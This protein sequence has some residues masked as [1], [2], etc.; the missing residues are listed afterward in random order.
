MSLSNTRRPRGGPLRDARAHEARA[1]DGGGFD[2]SGLRVGAGELRLLGAFLEE[3]NPHQAAR[4]VGLGEI[5]EGIALQAESRAFRQAQP[6]RGH[7]DGAQGGGIVA[8]RPGECLLAREGGDDVAGRRAVGKGRLQRRTL[9][10][11]EEAFGGGEHA[12][13]I[14]DVV[15]QAGFLRGDAGE[16]L[17]GEDHFQRLR[18]ADEARQPD[19]AAPGGQ[20][21]DLHFRQAELGGTVV[22]G[23]APVT[24]EG[25][26]QPT[27]H[28]Q[29]LN[30]CRTG[31]AQ[32]GDPP[33]RMVAAVDDAAEAFVGHRAG[34]EAVQIRAG[35][36]DFA[37][38]GNEDHAG[39]AAV[40]RAGFHEVE[41]GVEFGEGGVVEDVHRRVGPVEGEHAD[42]AWLDLAA[43]VGRHGEKR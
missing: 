39:D 14:G 17:A 33:E 3:E 1:N 32:V 36:E 31:H 35:D 38:G 12:F 8:A 23:D 13:G 41:V 20:D 6:T 5:D 37:F 29:P 18:Q 25:Q 2:D 26:L 40:A 15:H 16:L 11:R 21:A 19:G 4:H 30:R 34:G 7:V 28:A 9:A 24:S 42:A 43:D 22:A 10:A 27:A